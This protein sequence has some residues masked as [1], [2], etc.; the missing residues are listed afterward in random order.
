MEGVGITLD[1]EAINRYVA[2]QIA[3][4]ALGDALKAA[5][6][7]E[8]AELSKSYNNPFE[9]VIRTHV[10]TEIQRLIREEHAPAIAEILKAKMTPEVVERI[11]NAAW[12]AMERSR[13]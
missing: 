11:A 10:I 4:S 12:D 2:A 3:E 9:Q 1:P 6:D 5:V 13:W 7:K 8:V